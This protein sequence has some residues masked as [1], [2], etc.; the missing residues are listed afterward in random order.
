MVAIFFTFLVWVV[1]EGQEG[2][3][4]EGHGGGQGVL[5]HC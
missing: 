1:L 5:Q 2:T 3:I 4:E